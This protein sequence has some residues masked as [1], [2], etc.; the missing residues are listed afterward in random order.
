MNSDGSNILATDGAKSTIRRSYLRLA[1]PETIFDLSS[2]TITKVL[3][4]LQIGCSVVGCGWN[5]AVCDLHHI[6]PKSEGGT[7]LHSNLAY[8]CP[9][10]HRAIHAGVS[11]EVITFEELIGDRWKSVYYTK[12]T[13]TLAAELDYAKRRVKKAE[14]NRELRSRPR[15]RPYITYGDRALRDSKLL[16]TLRNSGINFSRYGWVNQASTI[17]GVSPQKVAQWM[18]RVCPDL[19]LNCK[20]R[21]SVVE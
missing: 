11:A 1:A 3:K 16:E 10:H 7:D 5:I 15:S 14:K 4:R 18:K 20:K 19:Y 17:I 12:I 8:I 21:R 13:P 9:N 6:I 2:R